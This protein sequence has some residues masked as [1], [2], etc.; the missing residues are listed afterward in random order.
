MVQTNSWDQSVREDIIWFVG[1]VQ[2]SVHALAQEGLNGKGAI[3]SPNIYDLNRRIYTHYTHCFIHGNN[4][5]EAPFSTYIIVRGLKSQN[6]TWPLL[7]TVLLIQYLIFSSEPSNL[8]IPI[9]DAL[10]VASCKYWM[11]LELDFYVE[12][13]ISKK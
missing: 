4:F 10:K 9:Y 12:E 7:D 8:I 1:G 13:L 11:H 5:L 6:L 2:I 3:D